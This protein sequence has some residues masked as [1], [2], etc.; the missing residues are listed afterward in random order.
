[1]I[2]NNNQ[3]LKI[4]ILMRNM[5]A[6]IIQLDSI[7]LFQFTFLNSLDSLMYFSI[8]CHFV[9]LSIPVLEKISSEAT[10]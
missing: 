7:L 1:M 3:I 8:F 6:L 10:A 4:Y 5:K 9:M 2:V